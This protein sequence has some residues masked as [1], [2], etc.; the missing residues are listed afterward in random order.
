MLPSYLS[1]SCLGAA[2]A[3]LSAYQQHLHYL[4]HVYPHVGRVH[5]NSLSVHPYP[6][7]SPHRLNMSM[8]LPGGG[9]QLSSPL[10]QQPSLPQRPHSNASSNSTNDDGNVAV[11]DDRWDDEAVNEDPKVRV[12]DGEDDRFLKDN[13]GTSTSQPSGGGSEGHQPHPT[14]IFTQPNPSAVKFSIDSILGLKPSCATKPSE[15]QTNSTMTDYSAGFPRCHDPV[16]GLGTMPTVSGQASPTPDQCR[17]S[18]FSGHQGEGG[19]SLAVGG[20]RGGEVGDG[21]LQAGDQGRDKDQANYPWLQC[22]RYH[23]P[24][25]QRESIAKMI[26]MLLMVRV[27]V[28]DAA[29]DVDD[30]GDIDSNGFCCTYLSHVVMH[31]YLLVTR[32]DHLFTASSNKAIS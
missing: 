10:L 28:S 4:S 26:V 17:G 3:Y 19:S 5:P 7:L 1:A 12:E 14:L 18:G 8:A 15:A 2:P 23:P 29:A 22:T 25:L 6:S 31:S 30:D 20:E 11:D 21:G 9:V 16:A 13:P 32:Y 24:K 27:L